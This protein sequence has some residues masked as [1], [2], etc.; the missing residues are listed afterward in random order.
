MEETEVVLLVSLS[1]LRWPVERIFYVRR[2]I[3]NARERGKVERESSGGIWE[4]PEWGPKCLFSFSF[5]G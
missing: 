5:Q 2:R 1:L 3:K 4:V